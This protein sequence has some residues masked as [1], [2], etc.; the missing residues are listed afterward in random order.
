MV[1]LLSANREALIAQSI[2][3][4]VLKG[5]WK[6]ILKHKVDSGLL[7][8]AITTQV[9]SELS[10]FS[11]Y[12]GPSL[13]WSF[14]IWTDSLPSS[15]HSLQSSWKMI[16]I[17]TKH[18]HFKTAHQLLDKLAQR[19]LLSS[20]LVLRSLVGGVSEDPEDVS[21]VF[22]WLMIYYAKA[23]MINDSIVVFEQIRS[24][25]LKPHLQACTV[26][27]N[28]LVKQRLTDTVWKI[29]K[30]MV[31]LGVVANIHVYNV[32]VHACSKSGDPEKA[33][34]LLSE[35]EEKE[36]RMRE[37]TR[38]FREIKDDVTA[39]H[40]TYTTLIDGYCRMN[41]IDEALRLREVMESRGFSPGV[42][43]YNSIL[44]KLCEDGRIREANRLLTEM[45]GKKIEPD[46]ITCNTLINAYCKIEDMVSAVKVKKKMIESGL[47]LDMYSYKA[48]I[49]GFCKVLELEN[50]KEELF[51]MIEKGFSPG[52]ATYSWL[53]D[54]FY[55]QNK[56]DE[57]T[58]LL[59]EFEKRGLC[60]D[61]A[62]YRGL[63]RRICK[64]EQVDYAKVLFE[65]ME[66]KGLVGDSVIFTTMAY[67]YWRT[68][69]VTEA[70]ALFDVMYNRRLMVNL[71]LY[72]SISASYAGDN[73]VLRF[74]WS[75]VGDRCLISKSIL[76]EMN[77][78]EVL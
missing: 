13:S 78:S 66:K 28:S 7:K 16:L 4:T 40:V 49:H 57:I 76:R 22:S 23:G 21:H 26:L 46:N 27:L 65:S 74:F 1:N 35:M 31:K 17:L 39:N 71:K 34:K 43:T 54:G 6:N 32:L 77:R 70:S 11:G 60:A 3:A 53:V 72:K 41:D 30:K 59:E 29:F 12:G 64:L 8:S 42:V 19:E 50:A 61:V 63:I 47:K 69:K 9:I 25:G 38:L 33:E 62:L 58:K 24:C 36:G 48:L 18:K 2:C 75:H 55:N 37:A 10:L 51:S 52:Y 68:G 56:Q 14:F 20:P 15:K 44:R 5:N 45:S 73:D 67:A